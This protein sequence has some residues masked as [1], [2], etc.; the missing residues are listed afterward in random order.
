V[1]F[2]L[3]VHVMPRKHGVP[4]KPPASFK[5]DPAVLAEHAGK[6]AAA[7]AEM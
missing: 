4:L 1:V 2:H 3:H 6:L 7:L 5:E